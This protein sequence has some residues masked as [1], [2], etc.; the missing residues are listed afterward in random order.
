MKTIT[1]RTQTKNLIS[2]RN[3]MIDFIESSEKH[4]NSYFWNSSDLSSS[5]RRGKEFEN[6]FTFKFEDK[7][8]EV[9][10][11]L[12]I[13][14]NNFYYYKEIF[15]DDE[16]RDIRAIKKVLKFVEEVLSNREN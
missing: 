3:T 14:C 6:C 16:Q 12:T 9:K 5:Q 4:K 10:E 1:N 15:V 8:F 7:I 2:I 11:S 13:S